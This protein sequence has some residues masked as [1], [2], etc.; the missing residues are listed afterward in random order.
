MKSFTHYLQRSFL[1]APEVLFFDKNQG[2]CGSCGKV[3]EVHDQLWP[4]RTEASWSGHLVH[5]SLY[6][7]AIRFIF[8]SL[9]HCYPNQLF[10]LDSKITIHKLNISAVFSF[11]LER[12]FFHHT[13]KPT[14][15]LVHSTLI[16]VF[17]HSLN[18][19]RRV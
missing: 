13:V 4:C 17:F 1:T 6:I 5:H 8:L 14:A 18:K 12:Q 7:N 19:Y 3:D 16:I 11:F 2:K 9:Y 10:Y 15:F